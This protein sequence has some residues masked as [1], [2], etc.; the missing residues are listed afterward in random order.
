MVCI[1]KNGELVNCSHNLLYNAG[2]NMTR[3]MPG[4]GGGSIL[5]ISLLN[6]S[7][8]ATIIEPNGNESFTAYTSCGLN[9]SGF[10]TYATLQNAPGNWTVTKTFTSLCD[11]VNTTAARLVNATGTI[12]AGSS[13]T[14]VTLQTNDQLTINWTL[15]V[16]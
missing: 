16:S 1:Y 10:G 15:M 4:V 8:A 7:A 11:N 6:A 3:D 13:F 9:A 2:R 12:F 5:N 14:L